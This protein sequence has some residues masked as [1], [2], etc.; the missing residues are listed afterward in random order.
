MREQ[1]A[2]QDRELSSL[3]AELQRIFDGELAAL[4]RL[5]AEG[6]LGGVLALEPAR[7]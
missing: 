2:D 4:N 5:A 6:G 3:V 7:Q 1:F